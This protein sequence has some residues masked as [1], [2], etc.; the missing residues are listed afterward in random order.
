MPIFIN[1][2]ESRVVLSDLYRTFAVH[3]IIN[4]LVGKPAF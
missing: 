4:T 2:M 3:S 1:F